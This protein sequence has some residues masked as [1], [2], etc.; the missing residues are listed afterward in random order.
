MMSSAVHNTARATAPLFTF[1][2]SHRAMI[3]IF[4]Q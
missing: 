4:I 2:R 3:W 1:K